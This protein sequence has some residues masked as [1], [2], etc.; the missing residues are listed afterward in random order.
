M[1]QGNKKS[2]DKGNQHQIPPTVTIETDATALFFFFGFLFMLM[3]SEN[4]RV[5]P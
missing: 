3:D 4:I 5:H 2:S 1:K